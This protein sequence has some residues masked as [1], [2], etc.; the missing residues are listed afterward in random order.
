M[1]QI[2]LFSCRSICFFIGNNQGMENKLFNKNYIFTVISA[3]LFYTASFM[4]NTVSARH[5]IR[6][7]ASKTVAG[8]VAATFTLS[9]FFTRPLWGYVTDRKGRKLVYNTGGLF[10]LAASLILLFCNNILLLFVS[11]ILFGTG[12]SALTTAGGTI[13]CDVVPEKQLSKAVSL[14]GITNVRSQAVAPAVALWL[15]DYGFVWVA[16]AVSV[17]MLL[18]L[19]AA[20]FV[21]YEE[22]RFINPEITFSILEKSAL[23]AAFTIFFFAMSTASVN[24]F[25]P[26]MA[27]E[28]QLAGDAWFF[29]ISALLLLAARFVNTKLIQNFGNKKVFYAADFLYIAAFV[30]IAFAY[31]PFMLFAGAALYGVGAGFIHPI[32]NT[33]AVSRCAPEK[34]GLATGTFM[35][36]QDLGMTIG[37]AVWGFLSESTGFTAVYLAVAVLLIIMLIVFRKVLL[38]LLE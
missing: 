15:Y 16:V 10:C 11:R 28:R 27:Q 29:I 12:Y 14:Y 21:K 33:A 37:A 31:S 13:I 19:I 3:T 36:S 18:V 23:P 25:I 1:Q 4:L 7:G 30:R 35:M 20:M 5:S 8:F 32:V 38:P 26:V 22:N 34:R 24:S 17:T 9:S 2:D 6:I